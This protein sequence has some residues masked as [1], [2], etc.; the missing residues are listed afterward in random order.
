MAW[1]RATKRLLVGLSVAFLLG[2]CAAGG[3]SVATPTPSSKPSTPSLEPSMPL[4]P[5]AAPTR[6]TYRDN[7]T[8]DQVP[9]T[10]SWHEASPEGV[11]I[12]VIA[13]TECLA[14]ATS[15]G[16][17]CV[18]ESSEIPASRPRSSSARFPRRRERPRGRGRGRT[19]A[20]LSAFTTRSSTTRSPWSRSTPPASRR[21]WWQGR[22]NPA[23]GAPT[24]LDP[25]RSAAPLP[26]TRSRPARPRG[27]RPA[28][29]LYKPC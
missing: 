12:R 18:S 27:G 21:L 28:V 17:D 19:S 7:Q 23:P 13:V 20:A 9:V 29:W 2:G 15:S 1:N 25:S 24:E 10:V 14:P 22:R 3:G 26:Q 4:G 11:G 6:A 5:P 8:L 16:V